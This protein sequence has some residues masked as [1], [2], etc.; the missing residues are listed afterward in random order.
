[1][2]RSQ[3]ALNRTTTSLRTTRRQSIRTA[4]SSSSYN[5]G[6]FR[7]TAG[8]IADE[9]GARYS[10]LRDRYDYLDFYMGSGLSSHRAD[11]TPVY[12]WVFGELLNA[13]CEWRYS[14]P[15]LY[16][17]SFAD[18]P[19]ANNALDHDPSE[20]VRRELD[21]EAQRDRHDTLADQLDALHAENVKRARRA[22]PPRI[23]SAYREVFGH[24]PDGWPPSAHTY[25]LQE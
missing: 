19:E 23:V 21:A 12:R 8:C 5:L 14:F 1:M 9:I 4:K 6:S 20:A 22:P 18:S 17:F 16:S 24:W 2:G 10:Q 25:H 13:G 7:G 15:R 3:S 11:L